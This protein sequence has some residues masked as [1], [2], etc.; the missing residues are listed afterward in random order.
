MAA[1]TAVADWED[2]F[3]TARTAGPYGE[4]PPAAARSRIDGI[5]LDRMDR[6][7]LVPAVSAGER[8]VRAAMLVV[9]PVVALLGFVWIVGGDWFH[10]VPPDVRAPGPN[11]ARSQSAPG[12][13]KGDRLPIRG[14]AD[15][16]AGADA[17]PPARQRTAGPA[18]S[19]PA[20]SEPSP[21]APQRQAARHEPAINAARETPPEPAPSRAAKP[22]VREA[23]PRGRVT[24]VAETRPSTIPGWTVRDVVGSEAVLQG[25]GGT[26]RVGRGDAVPGLG[27]V[28]TIVRWGNRLIVTTERGLVSTD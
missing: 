6:I 4:A 26:F 1:P 9:V 10:S 24:P 19:A 5:K 7:T 17:E 20:A 12:F 3:R 8:A 11:L 18:P 13:G 28:E 15:A 25:P 14:A 22:V 2:D 23:P 27:K 16:L 21:A